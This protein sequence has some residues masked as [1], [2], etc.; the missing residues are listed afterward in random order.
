MLIPQSGLSQRQ[1]T[2]AGGSTQVLSQVILPNE[3]LTHRDSIRNSFLKQN[4]SNFS[5]NIRLWFALWKVSPCGLERNEASPSFQGSGWQPW[6]CCTSLH[7][8][9]QSPLCLC[10]HI[11]LKAGNSLPSAVMVIKSMLASQIFYH[12]GM[13]SSFHYLHFETQSH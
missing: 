1:E 13:S 12:W 10:T 8:V 6:F 9:N 3:F 2:E 11:D 4:K 5:I 7:L